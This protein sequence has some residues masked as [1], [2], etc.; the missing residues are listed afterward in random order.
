MVT[1]H[2]RT[3]C[4]FYTGKADW[5]AIRAVKDAIS[6]PLI[7]NGDGVTPD[8]ARR[9]LTQSGADGIMIGR[10]AY[11]RPW[12]P[13]V[14]AEMLTT[15]EGIREPDLE[16]ELELVLRHQ[17]LTIEL[18]GEILGNKT[19]RKHAGWSVARLAERQLISPEAL[20]HFRSHALNTMDNGLVRE[21]IRNAYA[22]AS[23]TRRLAA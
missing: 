4:Q 15:G 17:D 6:I 23:Q 18:Y 11:G 13:G 5:A 12:W 20:Q 9:M 22:V 19:F 10:G 16:S 14:V 2:G 8:D 7:A 21:A 1:V 3:R